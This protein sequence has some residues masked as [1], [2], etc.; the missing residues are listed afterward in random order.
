MNMEN[1]VS[2][3]ILI[4]DDDETYRD[5]VKL[6]LELAGYEVV[7]AP[8]GLSGLRLARKA[9]PDLVILDLSLPASR[10]V[11]DGGGTALD[12]RYGHKICRMIKFDQKLRRTPVLILTCSDSAED[13][14][15]AVRSGADAYLMKTGNPEIFLKEVGKLTHDRRAVPLKNERMNS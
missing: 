8:D 9:H 4:V 7:A 3:R 1:R 12:R 5:M 13:T 10:E 15:L 11:S 2:K 14:A 6:R